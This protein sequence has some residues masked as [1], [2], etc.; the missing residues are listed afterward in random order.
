MPRLLHCPDVLCSEGFQGWGAPA[1]RLIA[2]M[3]GGVDGGTAPR[4]LDS[5]QAVALHQLLHEA[6]FKDP[7]GD[8]LSPA[9]AAL[10]AALHAW[11]ASWKSLS[12]RP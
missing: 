2:E 7:C 8:H 4:E 5:K 9:G 1:G 3:R 10:P 6:K 12:W 11:M